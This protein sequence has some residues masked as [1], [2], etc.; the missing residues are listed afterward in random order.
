LLAGAGKV[1]VG[2]LS[3][4]ALTADP[5][6]PELMFGSIDD[7][8]ATDV[9]VAGPGAGRSPS[10]TS[11]SMFERSVMPTVLAA[12]KPIVLDADALNA[13]AF[14]EGLA[15]SLANRR[16]A[17]SILTPH[18]AEAARMLGA[19]TPEVQADRLGAALALAKRFR[20]HVVLKGAGSICAFPDGRWSVNTTGN[21]G[22]SGAGSGDVLAGI[23]GALLAQR[24][25]A[26]QALQYGVCL[27]G[28]AADACVAKGVGPIGL[29]ASE[30]AHAARDVMN[31]WTS[32]NS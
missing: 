4:D 7:A 10:A 27:H 20:A 25:D 12:K 22:L 28:A 26:A 31:R 11:V 19:T 6:Q 30:V 13:I 24:L 18:P 3:P 9:L 1:R 32:R 2:L 23:I 8:L 16:H 15:N 21:A 14:N 29:T 5:V 17:E